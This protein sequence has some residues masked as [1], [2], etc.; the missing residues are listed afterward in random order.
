MICPTCRQTVGNPSNF[1]DHCGARLTQVNQ[2]APYTPTAQLPPT[3]VQPGRSTGSAAQSLCPKCQTPVNGAYCD[4]CGTPLGQGAGY[5]PPVLQPVAAL[6]R[7][8]LQPA[9]ILFPFP[10]GKQEVVIGREDPD[11]RLI[12]DINFESY[13]GADAGVSRQHARVYFDGAQWQLEHLSQTNKTFLNDVKVAPGQARPLKNGDI[14]LIGRL[15][16]LFRL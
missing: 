2:P 7:L 1:C 8:L 5:P 12:P 15:T 4:R 16:L 11:R 9:N 3:V 13:G 14:V 6:P 10:G